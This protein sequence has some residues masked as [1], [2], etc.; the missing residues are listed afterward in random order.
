MS[1][2]FPRGEQTH[3]Q[4]SVYCLWGFWI[5]SLF[6]NALYSFLILQSSWRGR[7]CWSL[8]FNCFLDTLWLLVSCG[9][10][11]R[12]QGLV[13]SVWLWYFLITLAY[14]FFSSV[15]IWN[16][17]LICPVVS[18]KFFENVDVRTP[19]SLTN[20]LLAHPWVLGSDE[21]KDRAQ[22][23]LR[24]KDHITWEKLF[25]R[26]KLTFAFLLN[27]RLFTQVWQGCKRDQDTN[28]GWTE[29]LLQPDNN[30]VSIHSNETSKDK[31]PII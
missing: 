30:Q 26:I 24:I 16:L 9:S 7:G 18:E 31:L 17:S 25:L 14:Y 4:P 27:W 3:S 28:N 11:S 6:C 19:D 1:A 13:C 23:I 20:Y 10:F 8:W 22:S 5:W 21:L 2:K 29:S 12:C 15:S